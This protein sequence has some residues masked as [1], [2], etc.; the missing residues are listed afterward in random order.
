MHHTRLS[1][2]C[3]VNDESARRNADVAVANTVQTFAGVYGMRDRCKR[4]QKAGQGSFVHPTPANRGL[5]PG[6]RVLGV[7][8]EAYK[9]TPGCERERR[10]VVAVATAMM[11]AMI[12]TRARR[13][14]D[15]ID[16]E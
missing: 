3:R 14:A 9:P 7:Y 13:S 4:A 8:N 12:M 11:T 16:V 2:L 15:C 10:L 6:G 5:S 1:H